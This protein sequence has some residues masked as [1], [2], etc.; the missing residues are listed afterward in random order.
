MN[1]SALVGPY[2]QPDHPAASHYYYLI[3][4]TYRPFDLRAVLVSIS[5]Y[6]LPVSAHSLWWL[7]YQGSGYVL[8]PE[9]H[10]TLLS[11]LESSGQ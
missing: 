5:G 7:R 4:Q 1:L 8:L 9:R 3:L 6:S 10:P 11:T 2:N